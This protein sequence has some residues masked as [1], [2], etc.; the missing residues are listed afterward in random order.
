MVNARAEYSQLATDAA[1]M[2]LIELVRILGE[3]AD[4][5]VLVGG[6][7]PELLFSTAD[8]KHVGST[9]VDLALNHRSLDEA[10]YRTIL[11]HLDKRGYK[12]GPQPFIFFREVLVSG[13]KVTVQV[14]LLSGEYG[15]TGKGRRHQPVQDIKAR[16]ARG[17][18]LA[19]EI[20]ESVRVEGTLPDGGKD[21]AI[22]RVA[23]VV[24]FLIM[25]GMAL[26]DRVKEKDAWDIWFCLVNY[27]GGNEALAK[28]FEP[29]L[30]NGLV[31]E[32]LEK[33]A[34][35]FASVEHVGPKWVADFDEL[36]DPYAR[37]IRERDA[38]ERVADLMSRLKIPQASGGK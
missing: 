14:D 21:A 20:T 5:I 4:D 1:R 15:G 11:Q 18:D 13:H 3:Y 26:A 38:Y 7:V 10:K 30:T 17:C 37:G 36:T 8:P 23:G 27:R 31:N 28:A 33:I 19:F 24:P 2:V 6:W 29:H 22:V 25:K 12:Q 35:K 16:K 34:G 9:D 32:G